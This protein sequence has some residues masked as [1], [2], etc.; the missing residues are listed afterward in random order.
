[1]L[2]LRFWDEIDL[3]VNLRINSSSTLSRV[4][5]G[6]FASIHRE[7]GLVIGPQR[8]VENAPQMPAIIIEPVATSKVIYATRGSILGPSSAL[9][10]LLTRGSSVE[11]WIGLQI[12]SSPYL[13]RKE[14]SEQG[15]LLP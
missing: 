8:A 14:R 4:P 2:R 3:N 11:I 12:F 7:I 6:A 10:I 1:M 13:L 5:V 9:G 15:R